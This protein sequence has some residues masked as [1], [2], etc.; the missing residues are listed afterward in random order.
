MAK[1]AKADPGSICIEVPLM[2]WVALCSELGLSPTASCPEIL[3]AVRLRSERV[4]PANK[5]SPAPILKCQLQEKDSA[6]IVLAVH[7]TA[8]PNA[9]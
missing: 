3:E 1:P 9:R 7:V 8:D 5:A 6:P 2:W 4:S